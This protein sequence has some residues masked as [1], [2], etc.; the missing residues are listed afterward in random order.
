MGLRIRRAQQSD[1]SALPPLLRASFAHYQDALVYSEAVL[2]LFRDQ[3]WRPLRGLVAEDGGALVGVALAGLREL[4]LD[5]GELTCGHIGPV[6]VLP[7]LWGKGLGA[8]L[9]RGLEPL[10]VDL[11]TLTVN[12]VERVGG[13]YTRLGYRELETWIPRVLDLR[14]PLSPRRAPEAS[15]RHA[16]IER[17]QPL[18]PRD[19]PLVA[20]FQ[21]GDS[22]I[23]LVRWP[24][25]SRQGVQVVRLFTAQIV[26]RGPS[27][28]DLDACLDQALDWA[29]AQGVELVW[30]RPQ[31]VG[32]LRGF[33]LGGGEGVSR[34]VLPRTPRGS[35]AAARALSWWPAGP[36]P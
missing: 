23:Q 24:V 25:T 28:P 31:V 12:R 32:G 10:S 2:G 14:R 11:L 21:L 16:L 17:A 26:A 30:G 4:E 20:S 35:E 6:A 19:A 3:W 9:V 27:G 7:E 1:L 15:T 22:H 18:Q 5:G 33:T 36:S 8:R 34:M 13:F 29:R